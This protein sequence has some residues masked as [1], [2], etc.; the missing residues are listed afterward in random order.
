[1]REIQKRGKLLADLH[2]HI[3]MH[4]LFTWS[5]RGKEH[6]TNARSTGIFLLSL[7]LFFG[8]FHIIIGS[9][10]VL[11]SWRKWREKRRILDKYWTRNNT[12]HKILTNSS[13]FRVQIGTII[14][15]VISIRIA[16]LAGEWRDLLH[17]SL[18]AVS[19]ACETIWRYCV[20]HTIQILIASTWRFTFQSLF[21]FHFFSGCLQ[22][23]RL[24]WH[25][26]YELAFFKC[27]SYYYIICTFL[28][29]STILLKFSATIFH[30]FRFNNF[31]STMVTNV[32]VCSMRCAQLLGE[33]CE[34][35]VSTG[36]CVCFIF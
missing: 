32:G 15:T 17:A 16:S 30:W 19:V 26:V 25:Q 13:F 5:V 27:S 31:T 21:S 3:H 24:K 10:T 28:H 6:R 36:F 8:L 14:H 23:S 22:P 20:T 2:V 34:T 9:K 4:T 1:M 12:K 35:R 7:R 29:I 18:H 33:Y 11:E